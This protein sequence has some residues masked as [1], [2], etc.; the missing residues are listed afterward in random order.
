MQ[1]VLI[2]TGPIGAGKTSVATALAERYGAVRLSSDALRSNRSHG[3][4][5]MAR[6]VD[7]AL[8][9]GRHFV[10]D[11]TGM[12]FRFRDLAARLRAQALHVH[13]TVDAAHWEAREESRRDR[14]RLNRGV[15]ERSSQVVFDSPPDLTLDT[16]SLSPA[17]VLA[18]VAAAWEQS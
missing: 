2:L 8:A 12:S 7:Q 18:R 9:H 4:H 15:Y 17:G 14:A 11:S 13:L 1:S 6:A 3:F 5:R 16:S 10:L